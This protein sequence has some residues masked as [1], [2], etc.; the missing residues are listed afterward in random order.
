MSP[1]IYL[2]DP[3][4]SPFSSSSSSLPP[5]SILLIPHVTSHFSGSLRKRAE[6]LR[7]DVG[8]LQ[9]HG[10]HKDRDTSTHTRTQ[11]WMMWRL[12]TH[13]ALNLSP[14]FI[15]SVLLTEPQ[16]L[17]PHTKYIFINQRTLIYADTLACLCCL[18]RDRATVHGYTTSCYN[19]SESERSLSPFNSAGLT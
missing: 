17:H 11:R 2:L 19:R 1:K 14:T 16:P 4:L 10:Q 7:I 12:C 9:E 5:H 8:R 18:Y 13:T 3:H 15:C 6:A